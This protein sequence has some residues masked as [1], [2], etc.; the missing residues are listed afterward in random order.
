MIALGVVFMAIG[1]YVEAL[2]LTVCALLSLL[3]VFSFME[4]G[5]PYCYIVWLGTSI[6]GAVFF[7]SHPVWISYF[8]IFGIYPIL[9]AYGERARRIFWI[10]LKLVLANIMLPSL[11]L[12]SALI[13]GVPFF[14]TDVL[15]LKVGLY[16][17]C[18]VAFI[19]YDV[20]LTVMIRF[21]LSN[22]RH[23][24]AGLLK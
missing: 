17:A 7:T 23:R 4:L 15:L 16:A 11:I 13:T 2:D 12:L 24:I 8:L 6:L 9:K 5:S 10:I 1:A 21:Y 22:V 14:G 19:I 20:F 3:V 18:L